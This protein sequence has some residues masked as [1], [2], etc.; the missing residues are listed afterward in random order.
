MHYWQ[1]WILHRALSF[2][3][4]SYLLHSFWRLSLLLD[5]SFMIVLLQFLTLLWSACLLLSGLPA[6]LSNRTIL[7]W[8]IFQHISNWVLDHFWLVHFSC[9]S[10]QIMLMFNSRYCDF[11]CN[12]MY[13]IWYTGC[14]LNIEDDFFPYFTCFCDVMLHLTLLSWYRASRWVPPEQ[15]LGRVQPQHPLSLWLAPC[16]LHFFLRAMDTN[17]FMTSSKALWFFRERQSWEMKEMIDR[18]PLLEKNWS[19]EYFKMTYFCRYD[20]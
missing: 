9:L 14:N 6:A 20:S 17:T 16:H 13:F 18:I 12:H 7:P 1:V 11:Y 19:C 15:R 8:L 3:K 4:P 10:Q 2:E 5:I